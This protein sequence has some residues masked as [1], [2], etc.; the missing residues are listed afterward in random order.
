MD[1]RT[2]TRKGRSGKMKCT[3]TS[4]T[5]SKP[6]RIR[7]KAKVARSNRVGSTNKIKHLAY[8]LRCPKPP[9]PHKRLW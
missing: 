7:M 8:S 1:L 2:S 6:S 9:M 4:V 5:R 3:R